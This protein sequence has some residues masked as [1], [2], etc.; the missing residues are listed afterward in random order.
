MQELQDKD[1]NR[2]AEDNEGRSALQEVRFHKPQAD[3]E[4]QVILML[5]KGDFAE[6]VYTGR[7]K[8]T[9]RAFDTNDRETAKKEGLF[10]ENSRY[11]A[12]AVCVGEGDV[13]AGLDEA[14]AGKEAGKEFKVEVPAEKGFGKKDAKLYKLV[15]ASVFKGEMQ[16]V[17]GMPVQFQN[18][19]SGV[20]KTVSGGRILVDFNH[21]L[22][23]KDLVYNVKI[24]KQVTDDAEKLKGFLKYY[25]GTEPDVEVK[26]GKAVIKANPEVPEPIQKALIDKAKSR[27]PTLK[28]IEFFKEKKEEPKKEE[29]PI[30]KEE[31]KTPAAKKDASVKKAEG[32]KVPLKEAIKPKNQ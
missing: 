11:D 23:G 17:P 26:E 8:E 1:E 27:I 30:V 5:K 28:E 22:A 2:Q 14:L 6:I 21:P 29:K 3:K 9:G 31:A 16:P 4:I 19:A 25:L 10:N 13:V 7:I 18:G 15:P 32:K 12:I 24:V 20:V